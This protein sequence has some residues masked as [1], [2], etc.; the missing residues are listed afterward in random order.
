M[1]TVEIGH[2]GAMCVDSSTYQHA[3]RLVRFKCEAQRLLMPPPL[4]SHLLS[5]TQLGF[6]FLTLFLMFKSS[7]WPAPHISCLAVHS[8][9]VW[10]LLWQRFLWSSAWHQAQVDY[11][12]R[13]CYRRLL[14]SVIVTAIEDPL[15]SS[16]AW[17]NIGNFRV[18]VDSVLKTPH[19]EV[20]CFVY[21]FIRSLV[22]ANG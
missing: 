16:S 17:L 13:P 6:T 2:R 11:S 1:F 5:T 9:W 22:Y 4:C 18:Y 19:G 20:V 14:F 10:A 8:R 12:N 3:S 15:K 21:K 7:S